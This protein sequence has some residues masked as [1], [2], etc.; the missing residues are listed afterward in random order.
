MSGNSFTFH[1][2]FLTASFNK[3]SWEFSNSLLLKIRPV[4]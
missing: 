2:A 3:A 4:S 1:P